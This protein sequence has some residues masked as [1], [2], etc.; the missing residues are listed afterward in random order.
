MY[1]N[2]SCREVNRRTRKRGTHNLLAMSVGSLLCTLSW[3]NLSGRQ[4]LVISIP[5]ARRPTS[6]PLRT[7]NSRFPRERLE[8]S[9]CKL[10]SSLHRHHHHLV[11]PTPP[12]HP[13]TIAH[14]ASSHRSRCISTLSFP[15]SPA[16]TLFHAANTATPPRIYRCLQWPC[17]PNEF[18]LCK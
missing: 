15:S 12:T 4:L 16:F 9:P 3:D 17:E 10:L 14:C 1:H 2:P 11:C 7:S 18:P 13:P 6:S 8:C 5:H